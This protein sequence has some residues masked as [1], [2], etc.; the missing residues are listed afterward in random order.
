ME[1]EIIPNITYALMTF[2]SETAKEPVMAKKRAVRKGKKKTT[3]KKRK[4]TT[5]MS[6][7]K[8]QAIRDYLYNHRDAKPA[9]VVAGLA[10]RRVKV[11]SAFVSTIKT[12]Y[13]P[14]RKKASRRRKTTS[15]RRA[16]RRNDLVSVSELLQAKKLA[17]QLGGVERAQTALAAL[18]KLVI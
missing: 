11:S 2:N 12:R 9:E 13:Q 7:N 1:L 10:K 17:A 6:V 15:R 14:G 3:R 16:V 5:K 8:S 4:R 18:A